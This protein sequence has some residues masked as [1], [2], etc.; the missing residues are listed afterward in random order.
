VAAALEPCSH[1]VRLV[2]GNLADP[3]TRERLAAVVSEAGGRCDQLAHAVAVTS[4]KPLLATRPNQWNLVLEV[5]ARS[6][7]DAVAVLLEPLVAARGAVVAVSSQGA[8]RAIPSYGALGPAKAA[9][10]ASVRQLAVELAP[11]GVRVNAVRAGLVDSDAVR[12]LPEGT[13]AHV[14]ARTPFARL[15][16]PDEIAAAVEFLLSPGASWI[17]GQAL[18]VDGGFSLV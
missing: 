6:L 8:T 1:A 5:S 11:R 12:R 10:E 9:L 2:D 18:E 14:A 7:L 15:G 17:V 4:F 3:A 16:T 13:G